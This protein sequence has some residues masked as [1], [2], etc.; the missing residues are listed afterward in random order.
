MPME[1]LIGRAFVA[2]LRR[3]AVIDAEALAKARI[4]PRARRVLFRTR[5]SEFWKRG[6]KTFQTGFVAVDA[7]GADWLVQRKVQFVGVDYLSVAPYKNSRP[8]H[9][10]L[11]R[12]GVVILEGVDL[13]RPGLRLTCPDGSSAAT[14]PGRPFCQNLGRSGRGYVDKFLTV[15]MPP[16]RLGRIFPPIPT[17]FSGP[18]RSS[19][20]GWKNLARWPGAA[21]GATSSEVERR[22]SAAHDDRRTR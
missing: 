22:I 7:S 5:N 18:A 2:D 15:A 11:L 9:Q 19:S 13:S 12:A 4:P 21:L 14:A 3:A 17:P 16:L 20:T 10:I 6:E 1:A 8:T